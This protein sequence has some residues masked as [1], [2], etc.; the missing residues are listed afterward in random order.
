MTRPPVPLP[1]RFAD[2]MGQL[3]G[4][5]F[6]AD[7]AVAVSGGGDSMAMLHLAAGWARIYGIRLHPVTVDHGLRPESA[8]EAALVA[9]EAKGLGLPHTTLK[10]QGWNGAGNLQDAA[11]RAR[12]DL[13][14]RWRGA[15]AHVLFGHTRDDQAETFL[16]RLR[17]GSGVE[18]L[19]AIRPVHLVQDGGWRIV[20][21]MLD[22]GRAELRHYLATLRIPFADDPTNEDPAYDRVRMRRLL[23]TLEAEGIGREG[24]AATATRMQRAAEALGARAHDVASRIARTDHGDVLIDRDAL[25]GVEADTSLRILAAALQFV[26]S[27]EYRPRLATLEAALDRIL[28][29]GAASLAG[30]LIQP[31]GARLRIFREPAAVVGCA[32]PVDSGLP[33]DSRWRLS[34]KAI[35]GCT[36]LALGEAGLAQI[37]APSPTAGPRAALLS[38]PAAFRGD[39]LVACRRAGFGPA[40]IETLAPP[41]GAFP[42]RLLVH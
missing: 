35:A 4:P 1:Q 2:S 3:L 12:Q 26:A 40:Y 30:C 13:I 15:I 37:D 5:D 41:G 29:G 23:D 6:P 31:E 28:G 42:A 39:R 24:L 17:R 19:G 7:I 27:A 36:I 22:I 25:A 8:A 16:M 32:V 34:G 20:R 9:D 10:W 33:W 14:G 21:P 18:G 11:R 38:A